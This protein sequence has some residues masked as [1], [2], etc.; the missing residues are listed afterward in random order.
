MLSVSLTSHRHI[1]VTFR[2]TAQSCAQFIEGGEENGA[3]VFQAQ[4]YAGVH[5]I[6]G[7]ARRT[8]PPASPSHNC[9]SCQITD[10][11]GCAVYPCPA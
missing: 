9:E 5:H 8:K 6:R 10:T 1:T 11:S 2:Q 4:R 3:C 7:R